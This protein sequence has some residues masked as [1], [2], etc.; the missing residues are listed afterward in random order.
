MSVRATRSDGKFEIEP[1]VAPEIVRITAP[2]IPPET[3]VA[4]SQQLVSRSIQ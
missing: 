2:E 1:A 3:S 4:S